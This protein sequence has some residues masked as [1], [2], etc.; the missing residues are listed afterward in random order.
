[1]AIEQ[2]SLKAHRFAWMISI[3]LLC[4]QHAGR[5]VKTDG[6]K[7]DTPQISS[8]NLDALETAAS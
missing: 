6:R 7:G 4:P 5:N 1:M 2:R 8:V 3:C